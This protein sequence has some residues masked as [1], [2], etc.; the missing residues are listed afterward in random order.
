VQKELGKSSKKRLAME[1]NE[2]KFKGKTKCQAKSEK[3]SG[4]GNAETIPRR[5]ASEIKVFR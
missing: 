5:R 2:R 3:G 1:K 4:L